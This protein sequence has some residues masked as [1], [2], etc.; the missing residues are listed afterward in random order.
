[1]IVRRV[2]EARR[3]HYGHTA[4][5]KRWDPLASSG[6]GD[7]KHM[8]QEDPARPS[9]GA[10]ENETG[11]RGRSRTVRQ[12]ENEKTDEAGKKSGKTRLTDYMTLRKNTK[13]RNLWKRLLCL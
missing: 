1:M 8:G 2:V 10:V 3:L 4:D 5:A 9:T 6:V 11:K 13:L 7:R 12:G